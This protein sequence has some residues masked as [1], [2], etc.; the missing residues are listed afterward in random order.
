MTNDESA[1]RQS[2]FNEVK[3]AKDQSLFREVNERLKEVG[4]R[5]KS[6]S[7]AEDAIC[8]CANDECSERISLSVD[9]YERLRGHSTWFAVGASDEHVF[10]DSER[11]IE[12]HDRYWIVEKMDDAAAV[13]DRLD[14]RQR[15][16]NT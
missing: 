3:A 10:P 14:P 7:Y 2:L 16:R 12:K 5:N 1:Q 13:A 6:L 4:E 15:E 9:E 11:V 8:E